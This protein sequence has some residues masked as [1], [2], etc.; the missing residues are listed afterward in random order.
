[1]HHLIDLAPVIGGTLNLAAALIGVI[2]ARPRRPPA[3]LE[4][5]VPGGSERGL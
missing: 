4:T 1:M 5:L 2:T 3:K